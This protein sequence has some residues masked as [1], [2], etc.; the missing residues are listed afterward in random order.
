MAISFN[1]MPAAWRVPGMF[2]EFD[3][4]QAM[5]GLTQQEYLVLIAAQKT[6]AGTHPALSPII[7]SS[8]AQAKTWFGAGSQAHRM[9]ERFLANNTVTRL[10]VCPLDD[11]PAGVA[12]TAAIAVTGTVSVAAPVN[13]F[14]A[15]R[16]LRVG[17]SAGQTAAQ[18]AAALAD[19]INAEEIL[20]CTAK[21][22]EGTVTLT[23]KNKGD[24]AN[25]YDIRFDYYS[26]GLPQ[27]VAFEITPFENGAGN[28]DIGDV[29]AAVGD[30]WFHVLAVPYTDRANL[31]AIETEL[32]DRWGPLR[33]IDGVCIT[34]RAGSFAELTTFGLGEDGT[35]GNYSRISIMECVGAPTPPCERAAAV[36]ANVAYYGSIDPARPFQTLRLVD[37][38]APAEA[39]R[40]TAQ[41]QNLLLY[42]GIATTYTDAGGNVCIQ[43]VISNYRLTAN[44]AS[45]VSY[46]DLNTHLTLSYL[47][48]DWNNRIKR[49]YPRHKLAGD[50][51]RF[52]PGQAVMTPAIG[53]SEAVAAFVQWEQ[54]GLVENIKLFKQYLICERDESDVNRINWRLPPDLM[55]QFIVG[56]TQ[57]QFRL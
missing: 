24:V 48:Y 21:A 9:V 31:R 55:N 17:T 30:R 28:P 20:C 56:A 33:Q 38:L 44:G 36:A 2:T 22:S 29:F 1:E 11:D 49:K 4:S 34:A 32:L 40:L 43:R 53:K 18:V 3:N 15:G 45:D 23:A 19:A 25:Q 16:S 47:R 13:L 57:I 39:D 50:E 46:L 51:A 14:I 7:V 27:G 52:A 12:A 5:Q 10:L 37:D 41:E 26:E 6:A 42:S 8:E 54:A 35:G